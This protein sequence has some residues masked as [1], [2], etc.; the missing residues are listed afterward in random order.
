MGTLSSLTGGGSGGGGGD[1]TG[2]FQA[3][4]NVANGDL[5]V[6]NNNGT[7]APVTFNSISS[8]LNISDTQTY[9][10][11]NGSFRANGG[12]W[13]FYNSANNQYLFAMS[14]NNNQTDIYYSG[15]NSSTGAFSINHIYTQGSVY[16]NMMAQDYN[17]TNNFYFA[18]RNGS[19]EMRIR[20]IIWNGSNYSQGSDYN[21]GGSNAVGQNNCYCGVNDDGTVIVVGRGNNNKIGTGSFTSNGNNSSGGTINYNIGSN[22]NSAMPYQIPNTRMHGAHC[23]GSVHAI[24]HGNTGASGSCWIMPISATASSVTYGTG[25]DTG[26]TGADYV[27]VCY[28]PVGNV[29]I[30]LCGSGVKGFTIDKS[31]LTVSFFAVTVNGT[32]QSGGL[33]FNRTAKLFAHSAGTGASGLHRKVDLFTLDS[34]G[35]QGAVTTITLDPSETV[36]GSYSQE[37][38][39]FHNFQ[40][41]AQMGVT[42]NND[43]NNQQYVYSFIPPYNETNMDSHFG[44]AKEAIASGAAG[45]VGI[46]NRSVDLSGS[47]F[48]KGQKLFANPSGTTLATSGTYRVG[49]ATDGD[50]VL[51]LGDPS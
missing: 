30:V 15:Y 23:G 6:L 7:V 48:N 1:P 51:V 10:G 47:S 20:T 37:Y 14:N 24:V 34:S 38:P 31:T 25:A 12:Q 18:Y 32:T 45:S 5:V 16:A 36:G 35:S 49:H 28:D 8:N 17:T 26:L 43:S 3:S 42:Y 9:L 44:E 13:A 40:G 46:L 2:K 27:D 33:G 22:Q 41:T 29:G 50:T 11:G 4:A 21:I 39:T 19:G